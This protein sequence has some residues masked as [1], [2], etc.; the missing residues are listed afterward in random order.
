MSRARP[1]GQDEDGE[2]LLWID[3]RLDGNLATVEQL[4][5]LG[6]ATNLDLDDLLDEAPSQR[7][8][9]ERLRE[10]FGED[11]V[12]E[13][14]KA[15]RD[16][17]RA[18]RV[19]QPPC[20]LCGRVG[21]STRHHFVNKWI[22]MELSNYKQVADRRKC[23][24]PVCVNCHRWLHLRNDGERS[25]V[26]MHED[27]GPRSVLSKRELHFASLLVERLRR[28]RPDIFALLEE[29]DRSVYEACLVQDW[30]DGEFD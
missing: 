14:V 26:T 5:L 12:P 7:E 23:T 27:D 25:I 17:L 9:V 18:L 20:R 11:R 15:H 22:M 30:L 3:R 13:W 2:P 28:E 21:D 4:E 19:L 24:I 1:I 10:A 16:E 29:G 6:A 8:V